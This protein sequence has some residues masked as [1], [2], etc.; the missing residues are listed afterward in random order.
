MIIWTRVLLSQGLSSYVKKED[1]RITDWEKSAESRTQPFIISSIEFLRRPYLLWWRSVTGWGSRWRSFSRKVKAWSWR[2]NRG[3]CWSDIIPWMHRGRN[4][5]WPMWKELPT[6]NR[7]PTGK[8]R[9]GRCNLFIKVRGLCFSLPLYFTVTQ[10]KVP[11]NHR[12]RVIERHCSQNDMD[13]YLKSGFGVPSIYNCR[14]LK[15]FHTRRQN[16][17]LYTHRSRWKYPW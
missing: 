7:L 11:L 4:G 1:G 16:S 2:R 3:N 5:W 10:G 8:N 6:A 15:W 12:F 17:P 14:T 9:S 13:G